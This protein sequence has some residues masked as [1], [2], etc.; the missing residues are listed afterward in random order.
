MSRREFQERLRSNRSFKVDVELHFGHLQKVIT[1]G[2]HYLTLPFEI[3]KSIRDWPLS[4]RGGKVDFVNQQ[5][6]ATQ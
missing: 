3:E 5:N 1:A 4:I 6:L 2:L